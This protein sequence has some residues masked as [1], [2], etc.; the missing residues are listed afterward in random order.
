MDVTAKTAQTTTT[1]GLSTASRSTSSP[2]F[3]V[4]CSERDRYDTASL[5]GGVMSESEMSRQL[6]PDD[7]RFA[8]TMIM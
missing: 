7:V 8:L 1:N 5:A 4:S 3:S 6:T 2:S